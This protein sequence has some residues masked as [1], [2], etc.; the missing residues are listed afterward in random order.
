MQSWYDSAYRPLSRTVHAQ[1]S[2]LVRYFKL[3]DEGHIIGV[4][5]GPSQREA[6]VVIPIA[7]MTMLMAVDVLAM[8]LKMPVPAFAERAQQFFAELA[9]ERNA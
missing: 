1:F 8:A 9:Q 6:L 2:E 4:R 3:S 5:S 7:G